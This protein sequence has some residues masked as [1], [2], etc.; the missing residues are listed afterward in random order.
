M[1]LIIHGFFD[2]ILPDKTSVKKIY[3]NILFTYE[4]LNMI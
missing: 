3:T 4:F 1:I 2:K